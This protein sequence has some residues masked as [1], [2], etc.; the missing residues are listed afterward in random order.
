MIEPLSPEEVSNLEGQSERVMW[1]LATLDRELYENGLDLEAKER[2]FGQAR[3]ELEITKAKRSAIVE[4]M[5]NL[6]TIAKMYP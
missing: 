2:T 3:I 4:R 5:R 1:M 6:K